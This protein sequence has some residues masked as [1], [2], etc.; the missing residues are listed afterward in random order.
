MNAPTTYEF[1]ANKNY[2]IM[3][4]IINDST[5]VANNATS[6]NNSNDVLLNYIGRII[7]LAMLQKKGYK[8]GRLAGNRTFDEKIVKAKKKSLKE[9]GLLVPAIIVEAEKAIAEGLKVV[10]FET[11][12]PVTDENAKYYVVLVDANHRY[13]A[14]LQLLKEEERYDGEFSFMLPLQDISVAKMLSEINIATNPWKTADYGKGAAMMLKEELPLLTAIN[15]LT[16]KGYSIESASMWL[17]FEKKI[18]KAVLANA[19][20]GTIADSLRDDKDIDRGLKLLQAAK[21]SFSEDFLKK[22]LIPDWI[23]TKQKKFEDGKSAFIKKMCYFLA[24]IGRETADVIEKSK[25]S[26]GGDPKE[27]I[28]NRMLNNLWEEYGS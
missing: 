11:E 27:T 16:E 15:S 14:H 12:E 13:K 23:I 8:I 24:G 10:D 22:R 18:T 1:G 3:S 19:I 26:R 7:T 17:T 6:M 21:K 2:K 20:S 9:T 25:G 4:E 5:N 28:V